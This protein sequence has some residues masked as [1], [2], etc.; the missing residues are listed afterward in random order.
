MLAGIV[1]CK[2]AGGLSACDWK[3]NYINNTI[4]LKR[5][6]ALLKQINFTL[7]LSHLTR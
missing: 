1:V 7:Y 4:K 2:R 5:G 3:K 6:Q